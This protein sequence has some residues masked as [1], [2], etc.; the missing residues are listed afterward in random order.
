MCGVVCLEPHSGCYEKGSESWS[1]ISGAVSL[2]THSKYKRVKVLGNV[3]VWCSQSRTLLWKC[4]EKGSE[5]LWQMSGADSPVPYS[6]FI[7]I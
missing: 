1:K 4:H 7:M 5:G 6:Q 2:V 3:D